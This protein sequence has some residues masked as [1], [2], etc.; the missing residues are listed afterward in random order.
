M[1]DPD[2]LDYVNSMFE[3]QEN[4]FSGDVVNAYN[5]GPYGPDNNLLGPFYELET[6]SPAAALQPN[7]SI[8]HVQSTIHLKGAVDHLDVI[9]QKTLGVTLK[10]ITSAFS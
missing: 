2:A 4:P 1:F 5:D 7:Q 10:E 3:I 9:A 8:H 6:S